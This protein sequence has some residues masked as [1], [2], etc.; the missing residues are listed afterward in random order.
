M[1]GT[2][3]ADSDTGKP[4]LEVSQD[5]D[6]PD[7]ATIPVENEEV[8]EQYKIFSFTMT[9]TNGS[10]SLRDLMVSVSSSVAVSDVVQSAELVIGDS[11]FPL[12]QGLTDSRTETMLRF[13]LTE[14][15]EKKVVPGESKTLKLFVRFN[16][17]ANYQS[18]AT[19]QAAFDSAAL[20]KSIVTETATGAKLGDGRKSGVAEGSIHTLRESGV[21]VRDVSTSATTDTSIATFKAKLEVVAFDTDAYVRKQTNRWTEAASNRAHNG[22]AYFVRNQDGDTVT[23]GHADASLS[24]SG[25]LRSSPSAEAFRI[26]EGESETITLT[27]KFTVDENT[28][29]GHYRVH[30]DV[31][32]YADSQTNFGQEMWKSHALA[33]S[34]HT[35]AVQLP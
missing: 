15:G 21:Y 4:T 32:Q 12:K 5:A 3:T 29:T 9:A 34:L 33:D 17:S 14:K 22:F 13:P 16:P 28:P 11:E 10:V 27:T 35:Q 24:S 31:F 1:A 6:N 18:D 26:P 30:P 19:I 23:N 25:L 7:S 2:K 20:R 8:S